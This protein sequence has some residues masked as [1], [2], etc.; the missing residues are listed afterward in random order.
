MIARI[1]LYVLH[2][3]YFEADYAIY[4]KGTMKAIEHNKNENIADSV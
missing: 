3:S 2:F 4:E 1:R